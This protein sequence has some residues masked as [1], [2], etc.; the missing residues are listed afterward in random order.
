[1]KIWTFDF[2]I[3]GL[4]AASFSNVCAVFWIW[5]MLNSGVFLSP[6]GL[7]T[8]AWMTNNKKHLH[9]EKKTQRAQMSQRE[10]YEWM[11]KW[12]SQRE[13]WKHCLQPVLWEFIAQLIN[14]TTPKELVGHVQ[15]HFWSFLNLL[16]N[17]SHP[18][19]TASAKRGEMVEMW[20]RPM[21]GWVHSEL[22]SKCILTHP[23]FEM[24]QSWVSLLLF[25]DMHPKT[26]T[27][28]WWQ[29]LE[30][31]KPAESQQLKT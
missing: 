18:A 4:F 5:F 13:I 10:S 21:R 17:V 16:I 12:K 28:R 14:I 27:Q 31:S 19:A 26:W 23:G 24:S 15:G 3:F 8:V 25:L 2:F 22:W 29:R 30:T 1:M 20:E 6:S 11:S 7:G 9:S